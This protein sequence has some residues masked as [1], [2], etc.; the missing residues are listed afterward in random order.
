VQATFGDGPSEIPYSEIKTA[1]LSL[2]AISNYCVMQRSGGAAQVYSDPDSVAMYKIRKGQSSGDSKRLACSDDADVL[3]L[4]MWQVVMKKDPESRVDGIVVKPRAN[5]ATL[6]P[7]VAGLRMRDLITA[8][9]RPPSAQLHTLTRNVFIAGISI[10]ATRG[11]ALDFTFDTSSATA[12]MTY[13]RSRFNTGTW[14]FSDTDSTAAKWF[15]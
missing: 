8:I 3:S 5:P 1:P 2:D 4:A 9:R 14:G 12:Y 10:S 6:V 13:S 7:L 15:I 11:G